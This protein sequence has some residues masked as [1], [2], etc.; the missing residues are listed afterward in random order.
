MHRAALAPDRI[1]AAHRSVAR[2]SAARQSV[3]RQ[4]RRR[5]LSTSAALLAGAHGALSTGCARLRTLRIWA[6]QGQEGENLALREIV[7]RFERAHAGL[8]VELSFFPDYHYTERLS[9]AAAA[10]DLPEVFE[11]DGPLVASFA[12]AGVLARIARYFSADEL[13]DFLPSLR[14]QG[15]VDG[16]LYTLGAYD[17]ASVLYYDRQRL[18]RAGASVPEGRGWRWAELLAACAR[19]GTT[20]G[21]PLALHA[22]ESHDEWFTYAFSSVIWSSGGRLIAPDGVQVRGVLA[23]TV[24]VRCLSQWQQL[25]QLGYAQTD[26]VDPDPFGSGS[27]ALDW[28]GHWMAR[29]HL[30]KKGAALGALPL[31][32]TGEQRAAPCG[33]FCWALSSSATENASA[34]SWLRWVTDPQTG[35]APLVRANGAVPARSSAFALFPEYQRPPYALF[36]AQLE[37]QARPRPVTRFYPT[38]TQRWAAALRDIAHGSDVQRRLQRAEEEVATVIERRLALA[39]QGAP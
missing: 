28:S 12:S 37:Q 9:I 30:Q 14:A 16:E 35:V 18:E 6:H 3:A 10:R 20:E 25:F 38:L 11:L 22:S 24:N 7:A 36:R 31:P 34:V 4:S 5:F 32:S 21:A 23:S 2:Q 29:A 1:I 13:A 19:L 39:R 26:P 15:T 17:S 27:A 33:S 8:T